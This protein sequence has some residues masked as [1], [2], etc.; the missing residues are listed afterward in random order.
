MSRVYNRKGKQ[1]VK[2]LDDQLS[3]LPRLHHHD[4]MTIVELLHHAR[5]KSFGHTL[6]KKEGKKIPFP[7]PNCNTTF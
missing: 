3:P 7:G 5:T 4:M 1:R 6:T 2:Y